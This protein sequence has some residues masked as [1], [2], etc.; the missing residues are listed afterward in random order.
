MTDT[1]SG[2]SGVAT[3]F[4]NAPVYYDYGFFQTEISTLTF[5]INAASDLANYNPPTIVLIEYYDAFTGR[6][7]TDSRYIGGSFGPS[8]V[9]VKIGNFSSSD[10]M[11]TIKFV[12]L[13]PSFVNLLPDLATVVP[14]PGT[15]GRYLDHYGV[16][17]DVTSGVTG[18]AD[19]S[20]SLLAANSQ[21]FDFNMTYAPGYLESLGFNFSTL[22]VYLKPIL[23]AEGRMIGLERAFCFLAGTPVLLPDATEQAIEKL[24]PG[25]WVQSYDAAG[26]LV[27][28]RVR[29]V[30]RNRVRHVLDVFGLMVT[31]GHVTLCGDGPFAGRHVPILDILRSDGAL[32][33]ADGSLVRAAT[34]VALG[35]ADD[36]FVWAVTGQSTAE[37]CVVNE[38]RALRRGTRVLTSA[39][40]D[41]SLAEL[42]A[43]NGGTITD[44]GLVVAS[45]GQA[46][47]F[48]WTLSSRLPAPEDY[49]L[50]RS[51]VTLEDIFH[52]AEWEDQR[53][54]MPAP[55]NGQSAGIE[56]EPNT[57]LALRA[58]RVTGEQGPR[59][60]AAVSRRGE[61]VQ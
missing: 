8:L 42:I 60:F 58:E 22:P 40:H 52:V 1:I 26:N 20:L 38:A 28:G 32:L 18:I 51:A 54:S 14:F 35:H 36:R 50:A 7:V 61:R 21:S 17:D 16:I 15:I 4:A 12:V 34:G 45:S 39:G 5:Q 31:P 56:P 37:G 47:P 11:G 49:V 23:N 25:D 13:D 27:P 46:A 19:Y 48:V 43:A 10:A 53:P 24:Q 57:P 29:R 33:R 55:R 2:L 30:I 44:D 6:T 3:N 41:F 9:Q 59:S